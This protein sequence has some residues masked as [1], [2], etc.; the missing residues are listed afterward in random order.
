M[1]DPQVG[2]GE[3]EIAVPEVDEGTMAVLLL[4]PPSGRVTHANPPAIA[5]TGDGVRLPVTVQDWSR[6]A[7]LGPG[8]Q[9]PQE[10]KWTDPVLDVALGGTVNGVRIAL[11]TPEEGRRAYWAVGFQ[12]LAGGGVSYGAMMAFFPLRTGSLPRTD[13]PDEDVAPTAHALLASS[14]SF[15]VSDRGQEDDPL[16]WV[17]PAF[18]RMT[19]YR[20]DDVV[21]RNC[22]FL[23]GPGTDRAEVYRIRR[24]LEAGEAVGAELLNYREEGTAFWNALAITPV[25]DGDGR[26][27]HF[28]GV[29]TDVT[30]QVLAGIEHERLL[31]AER[32]AREAAD[33]ARAQLAL[34]ENV[35]V[36]L[37]RSLDFE[38]VLQHVVSAAV[39]ELGDV[40]AVDLLEPVDGDR[41]PL[42]RRVAV[43][44]RRPELASLYWHLAESDRRHPERTYL[45]RLLETGQSVLVPSMAQEDHRARAEDGEQA[46]ELVRQVDVDSGAVVPLSARGQIIAVLSIG[47]VRGRGRA[48]GPDD[49]VLAEILAACAALAVDNARLFEAALSPENA[50]LCQAQRTVAPEPQQSLSPDRLPDVPELDVAGRHVVGSAVAAGADSVRVCAA[51]QGTGMNG[52][53]SCRRLVRETLASHALADLVD[54]AVLLVS[55]LV[56]NALRHGGGPQEVSVDIDAD[57]VKVSVSDSSMSPPRQ[58][59]RSQ[60]SGGILPENGRG[61]IL[62]AALADDWGWVQEPSGKRVWFR[63][64]SRPAAAAV[65]AG[66]AGASGA[67]GADPG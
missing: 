20:V 10:R 32:E 31:T 42:M 49:L 36:I 5:L 57:G 33:R 56:T 19:G 43:A 46:L 34:I 35:G 55:E 8:S 29:Q 52:P 39:P 58:R 26:I 40:C 15:T 7:G 53:A 45:T 64:R 50:H 16:I 4:D 6:A 48:F 27:T 66:A 3:F 2:N 59:E 11:T 67:A 21:G 22:R 17:D 23:Q 9:E 14:T 24:A 61:L 12:L 62:V 60:T 47:V 65:A 41:P 38:D 30:A 13:I 18:E 51:L 63:L 1:H 25:L 28:I 37:G 44:Y 54:S